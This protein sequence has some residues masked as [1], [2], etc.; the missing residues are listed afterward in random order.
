MI[1]NQRERD[2]KLDELSV[3]DNGGRRKKLDRRQFAYTVHI[4]ERRCVIDRR[5]GKDRRITSRH[6]I[7]NNS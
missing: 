6:P 1:E 7:P 4:P 2:S 3:L 5:D